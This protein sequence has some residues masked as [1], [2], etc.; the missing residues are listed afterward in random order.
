[1]TC[2]GQ[3]THAR[4]TSESAISSVTAATDLQVE[5]VTTVYPTLAVTST[6]H[7]TV[8]NSGSETVVIPGLAHVT[9]SVTIWKDVT[10]ALLPIASSAPSSPAVTL[11][12]TVYVTKTGPVRTAASTS[13]SVTQSVADVADQMPVTARHAPITQSGTPMD[14]VSAR[15]TGKAATVASMSE[16]VTHAARAASAQQ[17]PTVLSASNTPSGSTLETST[18]SVDVRPTGMDL[19]ALTTSAN[20]T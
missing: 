18:T 2:T 16:T 13:V 5:N 1:M 17:P 11:A 19:T 12:D 9:P 15:P 10:E 6:D 3:E 20:A 8:T 14:S 4:H 7:A